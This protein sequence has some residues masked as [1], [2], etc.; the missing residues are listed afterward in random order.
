MLAYDYPL[1]GVFWTMLFW[2]IWIAWIILLFR[3]FVDIFRSD[4]LGGWGKALWSIFVILVPFLGVFIYLIARG[5]SMGERA[6]QE[7]QQNEAATRAYIREAAGNG[8]TAGELE[9][10]AQ[11]H[12]D[13]VINDQEFEQQKAKLLA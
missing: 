4:D 9:K 6:A 8:G 7:A 11:L 10:L 2:F 1:L 12:R 13:G 3:V 5:H